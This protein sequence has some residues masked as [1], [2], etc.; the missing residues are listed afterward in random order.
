MGIELIENWEQLLT[1]EAFTIYQQCM[2]QHTYEAYRNK[3]IEYAND[4]NTKIFVCFIENR[5]IG[6]IILKLTGDKSAEL[7][8]IAVCNCFQKQGIGSFLVRESANTM[9]LCRI[10]AETDDDAVGFYTKL[11]F[12][13]SKETRD[14]ANGRVVRYH[15]MLTL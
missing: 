13:I 4:N 3:I 7:M 11:G 9:N 1:E 8:G 14:Y 5:I 6:M 12:E 15:C 2:Y 10:M